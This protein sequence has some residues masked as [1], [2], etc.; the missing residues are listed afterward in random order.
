[1]DVCNQ[2]QKSGHLLAALEDA[3]LAA[4]FDRVDVVGR[5]A[6]ETDDLGF[7][8]LR[9]K[10]ERRKVRCREWM[11]YR[12]DDFATV[13]C[14]DLCGVAFQCMPERVIGGEEEPA[15]TAAL[16]D[17]LRSADGKRVGVEHPLHCIRRAILA[18]E[19]GGSG[20][21]GDEEFFP[22]VG[23]MLHRQAHRRNRHVDDQV[24][25]VDVV[26][27]PCNPRGV[28]GLVLAVGGNQR[29]RLAQN[30]AAE[31]LDRHLSGGDRAW[32]RRGCGRTRK[33]GEYADF[34]HIVGNLRSG[35][36]A[37]KDEQHRQANEPNPSHRDPPAIF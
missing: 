24:D 14:D 30:L 10:D 23:D 35:E 27:L 17:C 29:N 2:H 19:V 11:R 21:M 4:E 33:V 5:P 18:V 1:M 7:R 37:R 15:I 31:I 3:E 34:H 36:A 28:V 9:L 8:G 25:F 32:T 20:R 26:P 6:G 12:S 13:V 22:V 16:D